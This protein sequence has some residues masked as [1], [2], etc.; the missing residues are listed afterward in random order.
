MSQDVLTE[1]DPF[2]CHIAENNIFVDK[3]PI[4]NRVVSL[5]V[6]IIIIG[7]RSDLF[8]NLTVDFLSDFPRL[9]NFFSPAGKLTKFT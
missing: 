8:H 6:D 5:N 2:G 4:G 1:L 9:F 3:D 7:Q